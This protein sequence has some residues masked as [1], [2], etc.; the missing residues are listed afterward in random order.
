MGNFHV[1]LNYYHLDYVQSLRF[2]SVWRVIQN[3]MQK[4]ILLARLKRAI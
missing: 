2:C 4:N 3:E 1:L